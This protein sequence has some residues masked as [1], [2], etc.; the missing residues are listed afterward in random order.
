MPMIAHAQATR[1]GLVVRNLL[2]TTEPD[3]VL[4]YTCFKGAGEKKRGS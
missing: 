3:G 2:R 1:S 4:C